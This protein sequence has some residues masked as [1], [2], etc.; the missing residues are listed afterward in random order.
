MSIVTKINDPLAITPEIYK[1]IMTVNG[2]SELHKKSREKTYELFPGRAIMQTPP[3]ESKFLGILMKLMN[4]KTAVEVGVFT[5]YSSIEIGSSLP[6]DG[7]LYAFDI[8]DEYTQVA[9]DLWR[10]G[11]FDHKVDLRIGEADAQLEKLIGEIG[12]GSVDF[13]FIDADKVSYKKYYELL[14][15]LVRVGGAIVFDNTLFGG[16]VIDPNCTSPNSIALRDIN[17]YVKK[18]DRVEFVLMGFADG[19]T[20]CRRIK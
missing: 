13:A 14:L 7:K 16:T 11:G 15:R 5:G 4:V 8:S 19:V 18:D 6:E 3:D 10:E 17:E 9:R 2:E 12:E 1:Y 20:V